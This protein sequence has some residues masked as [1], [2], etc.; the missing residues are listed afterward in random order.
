MNRISRLGDD[1]LLRALDQLVVDDRR[2][3]AELLAHIAE[4]DERGLYRGAACSS[5]HVYCVE[6][7]HFS[8]SA[9]YQR[10]RVARAARRFPRLL[11]E[12][13]EGRLHLSAICSLAAYLTVENLDELVAFATH[14]S[15]DEI[16]NWL[17]LRFAASA[18]AET[19]TPPSS[20]GLIVRIPVRGTRVGTGLPPASESPR[21]DFPGGPGSANQQAP[22]PVDLQL[23]ASAGQ[24]DSAARF[25]IRFQIDEPTHAI[26]CEV[27]D[28][29]GHAIPAGDVA[30]VFQRALSSL[31][32]DLLRRKT[33]RV[34]RPRPATP[35]LAKAASRA[36]PAATRRAVWARDEARCTFRSDDGRRCSSRRG[37]EFDHVIPFVRGGTSTV[38]GLRLRC[39]AHNQFEAERTFGAEFMHEKRRQS[40]RAKARIRG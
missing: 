5:M 38:E 28:L 10:I 23:S 6:R 26:L 36:I 39:R 12:V 35:R 8:A 29:L 4:V 32:K 27:Q 34:D 11:P 33:G 40:V 37:L 16:E 9:A 1:A 3:T 21:F 14:R 2:V 19:T 30:A 13:A 22:G 18:P 25:F 20:R 15:R 24:A 17:A 7:L 31:R